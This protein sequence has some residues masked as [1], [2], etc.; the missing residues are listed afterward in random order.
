MEVYH[1]KWELF[2]ITSVAMLVFSGWL[3]VAPLHVISVNFVPPAQAV[4]P[5]LLVTVDVEIS[6]LG[7]VGKIVSAFD[8]ISKSV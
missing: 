1:K 5:G 3:G 4:L 6:G 7:A 8:F 2:F